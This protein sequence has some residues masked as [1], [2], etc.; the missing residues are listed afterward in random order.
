MGISHYHCECECI[1]RV[2]KEEVKKSST[3]DEKNGE[4]KIRNAYGS[5]YS[6]AKRRIKLY[7]LNSIFSFYIDDDDDDN[8][9]EC[10]N[11]QIFFVYRHHWNFL[12]FYGHF[13]V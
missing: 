12:I 1:V 6:Y 5:I 11:M 10:F 13:K 4:K 7:I 2:T 9:W 8:A 3:E